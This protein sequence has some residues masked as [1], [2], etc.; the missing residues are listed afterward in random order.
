MVNLARTGMVI[1]AALVSA[2]AFSAVPSVAADV[3]L[4][5]GHI[6]ECAAFY[7]FPSP[8]V[9]GRYVT[10][11]NKFTAMTFQSGS[12]K[13]LF[14]GALVWMHGELS[15]EKRNRFSIE[16]EDVA[17]VL[18]PLLR[19]DNALCNE[20]FC[21]VILDAGH[22]GRD[23]GAASKSGTQEKSI[24]LKIAA[25]AEK[26]LKA[27]GVTV[28]MTRSGDTSLSLS[29][30]SDIARNVKADVFVSIHLNSADNPLVSGIETYVL[31][32]S[33]CAG[34]T[35]TRID[36]R[37]YA[38]NRN[39]AAN[40]VLGYYVHKGLMLN[41]NSPDRGI[42]RARFQVLRDAPCPAVLIECGFLSNSRE[43]A[44]LLDPSYTDKIA[45]GLTRGLLTYLGRVRRAHA[46]LDR[47]AR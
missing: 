17:F 32:V 35:S 36:A 5:N 40:T 29:Q 6:R 13:L 16:P 44:R 39:D 43:E 15:P 37:K 2:A 22:G 26:K 34:T 21:A 10:L 27:A 47:T 23:E 46:I 7:G 9:S 33:G 20:G 11:E 24:V 41:A 28:H 4:P 19:A 42:R 1:G 31:T 3:K 18:D 12:R 8:R 25:A 38:G 45:D 30:R 14:N